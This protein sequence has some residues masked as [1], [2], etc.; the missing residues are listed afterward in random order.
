MASFKLPAIHDNPDGWGPPFDLV[1]PK[2]THTPYA[3]FSKSDRLGRAADWLTYGSRQ[4]RDRTTDKSTAARF[5]TVDNR[6]VPRSSAAFGRGRGR[7]GGFRGRGSR[8][9]FNDQRRFDDRRDTQD[10]LPRG[11]GR[12]RGRGGPAW[13]GSG[14][15]G[16]GNR[17]WDSHRNIQR[18]P[19]VQVGN[20]W[21]QVAQMSSSL[22]SKLSCP[23]VPP[24]EDLIR[25]GTLPHYNSAMDH[26]SVQSARPLLRA[27]NGATYP[28]VSTAYDPVIRRLAYANAGSVFA[29]APILSAIITA[30]RCVQ[31]WDIVV[32]RVAGMLFFDKRDGTIFDLVT[33]R[34]TSGEAPK[35][36]KRLPANHQTN[37][38]QQLCLE[39]TAINSNFAQMAVDQ[40]ATFSY[41]EPN[42]FEE[43]SDQPIAAAG[44]KY[45]KWTLSSDITLVAR[46]DVEGC[47]KPSA[48]GA[49]PRPILIRA[50]NEYFDAYL[51]TNTN[52]RSTLEAQSG[53]VLATE[54]RNNASKLARWTVEALLADADE[55]KFGF[56]SRMKQNDSNHHFV[57]ATKGYRPKVFATQIA[58]TT[59]NMWGILKHVLE[60][61]FK[62]LE[63]GEKGVLLKDPN[64]PVVTLFKVPQ[65]VLTSDD[66][67]QEEVVKEEGK[68]NGLPFSCQK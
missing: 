57:L 53:A 42:P 66:D 18:E 65:D 40:S 3:P 49:E 32:E 29:T 15:G 16:K 26:V 30:S 52:W 55:M 38:F 36:E 50:L 41:E 39:A 11:H 56:V 31:S 59:A 6:M 23:E 67:E 13:R 8:G 4:E 19:S 43:D 47:R 62:H 64:K 9:R 27:P 14:A 10:S 35:D 25:C 1:P 34:E 61:C 33:L 20:D 5:A 58:L 63:D 22:L 2:F 45:R 51:Q 48:E 21:V 7:I 68:D 46:C 17:R 54:I 60:L 24:V 37:S 44:Y 28:K 12:G